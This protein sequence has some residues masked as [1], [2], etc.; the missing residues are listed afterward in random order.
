MESLLNQQTRVS[1]QVDHVRLM[2]LPAYFIEIPQRKI[3]VQN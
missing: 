2:A 3:A 1:I